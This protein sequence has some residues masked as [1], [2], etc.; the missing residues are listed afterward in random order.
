MPRKPTGSLHRGLMAEQIV[1]RPR[2]K[3]GGYT[4]KRRE[5][6]IHHSICS[7]LKMVIL[8]QGDCI[9]Y[10]GMLYHTTGLEQ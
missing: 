10:S 6:N 4:Y 1:H 3:E 9:Q 8:C 2:N 7:Q 5:G